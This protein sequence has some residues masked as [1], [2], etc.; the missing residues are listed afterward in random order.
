M[1]LRRRTSM[2]WTLCI[3]VLGYGCLWQVWLGRFEV[4][5][6]LLLGVSTS[7][8]WSEGR[9]GRCKASAV[10]SL[11]LGGGRMERQPTARRFPE[12]YSAGGCSKSSSVNRLVLA[13]GVS[14][15][16]RIKLFPI[17]SVAHIRPSATLTLIISIFITVSDCKDIPTF[18][19]IPSRHIE[20]HAVWGF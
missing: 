6:L 3:G 15:Q 9:R 1:I 7:G 20:H 12:S 17:H 18:A 8:Q 10:S 2:L 4:V 5:P 11:L 16:P 14:N 13:D 19:C